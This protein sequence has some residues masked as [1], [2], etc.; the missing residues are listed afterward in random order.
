MKKK[1]KKI[2]KKSK[3]VVSLQSVS[4]RNEIT[5]CGARLVTTNHNRLWRW[6]SLEEVQV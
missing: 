2:R 5:W 6:D 3:K 1:L 4:Q